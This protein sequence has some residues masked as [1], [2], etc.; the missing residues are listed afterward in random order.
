MIH[1]LGDFLPDAPALPM[2]SAPACTHS[3]TTHCVVAERSPDS[4]VKVRAFCTR[5]GERVPLPEVVRFDGIAR[6]VDAPERAE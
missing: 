2:P 5:C 1:K 6:T 3:D 4:G